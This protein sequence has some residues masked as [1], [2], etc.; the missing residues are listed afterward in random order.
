MKWA[1]QYGMKKYPELQY[2]WHTPNG[3]KRTKTEAYH[4]KQMGVKP[5]VPDLF[6]AVPNQHY[7]G[8]F[9]EMKSP[10]GKAT[11][12]QLLIMEYLHGVGYVVEV[13]TNWEEAKNQLIWYLE[14]PR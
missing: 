14:I 3:G 5:G 13:C 12:A 9:I 2:L 1:T 8:C 10:K 4:F 7:H 6:L 11:E